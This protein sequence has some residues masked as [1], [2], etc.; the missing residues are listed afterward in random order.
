MRN[1]RVITDSACDLS[2]ELVKAYE[3]TVV[4]LN[5]HFGE[6]MFLDR[7][8][9]NSEFYRQMSLSEKLPKTSPPSTETFLESYKGYE[10]LI[11]I[12]ISS[13]LSQ[14]YY[15][16]SLAKIMCEE[17][18]RKRKIVV[19][20][21]QLASA[22]QGQL[23][24]AAAKLIR[25][26]RSF[27]EI[28]DILETIKTQVVSYGMLDTLRNVSEGGKVN[29]LTGR[30]ADT[31]DFKVILD[32]GN[33]NVN[34]VCKVKGYNNALIKIQKLICDR[35]TDT[36]KKSLFIGHAN[37]LQKAIDMKNTMT[38]CNNFASINIVEVGATMGTY[39]GEGF[40]LAS[41]L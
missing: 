36:N 9:K 29:S 25:T 30:I 20:D 13:K 6:E 7:S 27:E 18:N 39:A 26:G 23:V 35:C 12:T 40:I 32:T 8:M 24:I 41:V 22:P 14:T 17:D 5:V 11:V 15:N 19:I 21:S 2:E 3:I 10:D 1:I 38:T 28:V 34:P 37:N 33:D 16:A 4:P 31:L